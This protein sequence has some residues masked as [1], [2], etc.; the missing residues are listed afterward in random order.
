MSPRPDFLPEPEPDGLPTAEELDARRRAAGSR[1]RRR[2]GIRT[3]GLAAVVTAVWLGLLIDP[4]LRRLAVVT[5]GGVALA[6]ALFGALMGL[7]WLGF[8]LFALGDRAAGRFREATRWPETD[9]DRFA[10]LDE[11][12]P[13]P[14]PGGG[15]RP[16]R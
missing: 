8:G 15:H 2:R 14:G 11:P 6:L 4:G 10:W 7:G 13:G 3:L 16:D 1:D 5:A 12:G 9:D